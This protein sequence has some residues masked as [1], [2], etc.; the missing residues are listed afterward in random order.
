MDMQRK[1]K[2]KNSQFMPNN[3][4]L[5]PLA[6]NAPGRNK[7]ASKFADL[8]AAADNAA[9]VKIFTII[10]TA[11]P[12]L[13]PDQVADL[14]LSEL[15]STF[16]ASPNVFSSRENFDAGL[17]T[18]L[19]NL[20]TALYKFIVQ[21]NLSVTEQNF[22]IVLGVIFDHYLVLA[23]RGNIRSV[24]FHRDQ[25]DRFLLINIAGFTINRMNLAKIFCQTVGGTIS[26]RDIVFISP[27]EIFDLLGNNS[28]KKIVTENNIAAAYDTLKNEILQKN[29]SQ[30]LLALIIKFSDARARVLSA[31]LKGS[32]VFDATNLA[33]TLPPAMINFIKAAALKILGAGKRLLIVSG[34]LAKKI[35]GLSLSLL[36]PK[37]TASQIKNAAKNKVE[38]GISKFNS[39]P[40]LSKSLL[41]IFMVIATTLLQ[42][43]YFLNEK[44][45]IEAKNYAVTQKIAIIRAEKESAESSLT[46]GDKKTAAELFIDAKNSVLDILKQDKNSE[47]AKKL[48][49]EIEI[50][51]FKLNKIIQID[52][53]GVLAE[54]PQTENTK[55]SGLILTDNNLYAWPD[56][57]RA[58]YAVSADGKVVRQTF[59]DNF[60]FIKNGT[61]ANN[62]LIFSQTVPGLL[63]IDIRDKTIRSL[64][65]ESW[66]EPV[67]NLYIFNNNLYTIN[68]AGKQ[69]MKFQPSSTGFANPSPWLVTPCQLSDKSSISIDTAI[70][71]AENGEISEF[72]RGKKTDFSA[73]KITPPMPK[74]FKISATPNY[75]Y[76]LDADAKRLVVY[77]KKGELVNQYTSPVFNNLSG[78]SVS[79]K[80]ERIYFLNG[81]KIYGIIATHLAE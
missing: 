7:G 16:T 64:L 32:L 41:I 56:N 50:N 10:Q 79:E 78:F 69:I 37:K 62:K 3:I 53:P 45:K 14:M 58:I 15:K 23:T 18:A 63:E 26:E 13:A 30:N 60:G 80:N 46:Y 52:T 5:A 11:V 6:I 20:N 38:D 24:L 68:P 61:Y 72:Y 51:L 54:L 57:D 9:G 48:L 29:F 25:N 28:I 35:P 34:K 66:T 4:I 8:S 17:E 2:A 42:G 31:K 71:I 67:G 76:A 12:S 43:I 33:A 40:R 70:Y 1:V 77:N 65:T 75:I 55:F 39:L 59:T 81:N 21:K 19:K 36:H 73:E 22:N 49:A 44:Y 47:D 74:N 27:P